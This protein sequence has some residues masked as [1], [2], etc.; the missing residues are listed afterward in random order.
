MTFFQNKCYIHS[1]ELWF[2][3]QIA[4]L[5]FTFDIFGMLLKVFSKQTDKLNLFLIQMQEFLQFHCA[6]VDSVRK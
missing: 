5:V 6:R 4:L 1:F 2:I 3:L